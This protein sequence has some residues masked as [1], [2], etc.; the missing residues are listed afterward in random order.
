M[1]F[2]PNL[3]TQMY[4]NRYRRRKRDPAKIGQRESKLHTETNTHIQ[5]KELTPQLR[6]FPIC[7]NIVCTQPYGCVLLFVVSLQSIGLELVIPV[8]PSF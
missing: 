2:T 8:L 7:N 1:L 6:W 5:T 3:H 4:V